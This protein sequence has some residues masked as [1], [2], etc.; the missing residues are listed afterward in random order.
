MLRIYHMYLIHTIS[1]SY[2]PYLLHTYYIYSIHTISTP[3]VRYLL[4]TY[5]LY[6]I[7]VD[8]DVECTF[9]IRVCS[10]NL[11]DDI[12]KQFE[13]TDAFLIFYDMSRPNT[14]GI[15][16]SFIKTIISCQGKAVRVI[17]IKPV[18][19]NKSV[20][21]KSAKSKNIGA[22]WG[23]YHHIIVDKRENE[24][25]VHEIYRSMARELL[26]IADS[27]KTKRKGATCTI[28]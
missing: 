3:Y 27:K 12:G 10:T 23:R 11:S 16:D 13:S 9:N 20:K 28:L 14:V 7:Q 2:V 5:Y 21:R 15:Y 26:D 24:K 17:G 25:E 1:T 4:H 18:S 22:R 6:P 8:K 19:T